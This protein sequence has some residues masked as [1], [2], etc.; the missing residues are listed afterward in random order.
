M[1]EPME[2]P[3]QHRGPMLTGILTAMVVFFSVAFLIMITG[4]WIGWI[5]LEVAV[6]GLVYGFHYLT[7][8][9]LLSH[10]VAGEREEEMLRRRAAEKEEETEW[11]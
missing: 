10:E 1:V 4:G 6:F 2:S 8:G 11:T 5:V 7:W 3:P 9:K